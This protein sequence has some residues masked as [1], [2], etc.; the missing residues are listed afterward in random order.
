MVTDKHMHAVH[1]IQR[2]QFSKSRGCQSTLLEQNTHPHMVHRP[3][4]VI[5]G[6]SVKTYFIA[7]YSQ[8]IC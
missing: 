2:K 3:H 8:Y 4:K 7:M 5:W 1:N 6:N